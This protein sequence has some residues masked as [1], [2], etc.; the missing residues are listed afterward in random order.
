MAYYNAR[1]RICGVIESY[2]IGNAKT[3]AEQSVKVLKVAG[4]TAKAE[5]LIEQMREV[6]AEFYHH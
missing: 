4:K 5:H 1:Q 3:C 2:C 6:D